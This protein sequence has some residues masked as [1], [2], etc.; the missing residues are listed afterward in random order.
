M[1][2]ASSAASLLSK[3]RRKFHP[4]GSSPW[5]V[6]LPRAPTWVF[7]FER[8]TTASLQHWTRRWPASMIS[9][10]RGAPV[11]VAGHEIS[12]AAPHVPGPRRTRIQPCP[13]RAA[14]A[15][16]PGTKQAC[17]APPRILRHSL[18]PV[19]GFRARER[20]DFRGVTGVCQHLCRHGCDIGR[21][22][23]SPPSVTG[24]LRKHSLRTPNVAGGCLFEVY[25]F[26]AAL[27]SAWRQNRRVPD[28]SGSVESG[29]WCVKL[30]AF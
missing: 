15:D 3:F 25:Y 17:Q 16:N 4:P 8:L 28:R 7:R 6:I 13:V 21:V 27:A 24:R 2:L 10:R 18:L 1:L 12:L 20:V 19:R 9:T 23:G 14:R 11:P 26:D 5:C 22:D 30:A 29:G